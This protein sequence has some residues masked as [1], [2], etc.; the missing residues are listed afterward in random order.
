MVAECHGWW[1]RLIA[2]LKRDGSHSGVAA[3]HHL[4]SL[5]VMPMGPGADLLEVVARLRATS[6]VEM[7]AKSHM[8][9]GQGSSGRESG[10]GLGTVGKNLSDRTCQRSVCDVASDPSGFRSGGILL[11]QQ[12][13][14]HTVA[15]H[16]VLMEAVARLSLDQ[17][18][19][20]STMV[21]RRALIASLQDLPQMEIIAVRA[22][23]Q[24]MFHQWRPRK[25]GVWQHL[26]NF[27]DTA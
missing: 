27:P 23:S 3:W 24:C 9:R 18:H 13:W 22:A 20:A 14:R 25:S 5:Y 8:G 21:R 19:F 6:S 1:P 12:P 7:V 10:I 15:F 11:A 2:A 26:N 17:P 16:R 4:S